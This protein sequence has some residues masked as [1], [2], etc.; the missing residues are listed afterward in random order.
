MDQGMRKGIRNPEGEVV[1]NQSY[2][3]QTLQKVTLYTLTQVSTDE[4][5]YSPS[6][7]QPK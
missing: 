5:V 4:Q 1:L 6:F 7:I 3:M 2:N